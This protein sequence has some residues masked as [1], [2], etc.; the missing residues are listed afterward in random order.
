MIRS[1]EFRTDLRVVHAYSEELILDLR[2]VYDD[3]EEFI[4]YF[5]SN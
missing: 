1:E 2:V 3:S 5:L 4:I